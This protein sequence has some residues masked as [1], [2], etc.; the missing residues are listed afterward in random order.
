MLKIDSGVSYAGTL[1]TV[2]EVKLISISVEKRIGYRHSTYYVLPTMTHLSPEQVFEYQVRYGF[3]V[4]DVRLKLGINIH[5]K[6][7]LMYSHLDH[8]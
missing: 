4:V 8:W 6:W 3:V 7:T 1:T 5:R 2:T